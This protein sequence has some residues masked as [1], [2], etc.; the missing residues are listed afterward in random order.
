MARKTILWGGV[1]ALVLLSVY[2]TSHYSISEPETTDAAPLRAAGAEAPASA[3]G[4]ESPAS[5]AADPDA[6][7]SPQD[8]ASA[9][10]P[11]SPAAEELELASDFT[12]TDLQGNTVSLSD[13]K[14][15]AVYLNFW[16]TWCKWC[17]KEM[18]EMDKF[19]EA[20]KDQGLVILAIS[21]GE[22]RDTVAQY[23]EEY[24]YKFGVLLDPDKS[25]AQQYGVKPIPVSIF[26]DREGR[27]VHRKLGYLREAEMQKQ[28]ER[29]VG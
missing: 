5:P 19:G 7:A 21:V 12:L 17:K 26:I 27:I 15:K 20:Y 10:Q 3:T 8:S 22:D 11:A 25:I 9:E 13:F 18:P 2:V 29:I 14:G 1:L 16:A 23:I 28:I 6:T 4:S 24:G